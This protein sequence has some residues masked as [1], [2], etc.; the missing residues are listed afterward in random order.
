MAYAAFALYGLLH[1]ADPAAA[2]LKVTPTIKAETSWN[3]NLYLKDIEDIQYKINPLLTV[4]KKTE[5]G[6][7]RATGDVARY[8]YEDN[9]QYNRTNILLN[10]SAEHQYT[11]R[12]ALNLGVSWSEDYAIEDYLDE[13]GAHQFMAKRHTSSVMPGFS[14]QLTDKDSLSVSGTYSKL[15]YD[16]TIYPDYDLWAFNSTWQ[17]MLLDNTLALIVQGA[18]Q[19]I[20]FDSPSSTTTQNVY[21]GMGGFYWAPMDKVTVQALAGMYFIDSSTRFKAFGGGLD[22]TSSGFAGDLKLTWQD[23]RWKAEFTA[24][25]AQ[26]PSIYGELTTR[27]TYMA[28][29]RYSHDRRWYSVTQVSYQQNESSGDISRVSRETWYYSLGTYYR[30]TE[31]LY[32]GIVYRYMNNTNKLADVVRDANSVSLIIAWDF[33]QEL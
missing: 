1:W 6:T 21:T 24:N 14:Y 20:E 26:S 10:A 17:H 23:E 18:W 30:F 19:N 33:P 22:S 25:Q 8:L 31:D 11:E 9:S 5:R 29:L 3:D 28:S 15:E 4:E 12:L 13:V 32:S 2:Q 16:V 27:N 7:L